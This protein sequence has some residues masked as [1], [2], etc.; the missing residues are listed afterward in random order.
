[1]KL[2][3]VLNEEFLTEE[4]LNEAFV[5]VLVPLMKKYL[6]KFLKKKLAGIAVNL[7]ST[8]YRKQLANSV[9]KDDYKATIE[10]IVNA[11]KFTEEDLSNSQHLEIERAIAQSIFHISNQ[12]NKKHISQALSKKYGF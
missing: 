2:E 4:E 12:K 11:D 6:I 10:L 1:M 8:D 3:Q 5:A 9:R 7:L